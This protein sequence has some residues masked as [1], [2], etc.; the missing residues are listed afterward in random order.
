MKEIMRVMIDIK[1]TGNRNRLVVTGNL[2]P[3]TK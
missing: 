1:I 2:N 3:Y